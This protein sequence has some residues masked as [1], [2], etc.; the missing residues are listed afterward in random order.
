[1]STTN[2]DR[3]LDDIIKEQRK[4]KKKTQN[5]KAQQSKKKGAQQKQEKK[6]ARGTVGS[7]NR[8]RRSTGKQN[9][10]PAQQR[11]G[12]QGRKK[13][14]TKRNNQFVQQRQGAQNNWKKQTAG[15]ASRAKPVGARVNANRLK[16]KQGS[17]QK[18][19]KIVSKAKQIQQNRRLLNR[20]N[21]QT[22][23]KDARQNIINK[24][25][26]GMQG[27]LKGQRI[28]KVKNTRN[29]PNRNSVT[30]KLQRINRR[31][32]PA[33]QL[34]VSINN[35]RVRL[36]R[37]QSNQG[38]SQP[39]RRRWRGSFSTGGSMDTGDLRISVPNNLYRPPP[40]KP[41]KH[42]HSS[43]FESSVGNTAPG[44]TF[45]TLNERFSSIPQR[46]TRTIVVD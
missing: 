1:M 43:G 6:Q 37:N 7:Q 4:Q 25:R 23:Q 28:N 31:G 22:Q 8:G 41:L 32:N 13:A 24:R 26:G 5:L 44:K 21:R 19:K 42:L 27:T 12:T 16:N 30:S 34:T 46:G 39:N 3:S 40:L 45:A 33:P 15:N 2:I 36:N 20:Q 18:T 38:N 29:L 14:S 11:Q 17:L 10:R 9:A 35:P